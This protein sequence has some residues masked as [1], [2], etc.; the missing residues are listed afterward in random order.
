ML[1]SEAA[2][3]CNSR[4][5]KASQL[6]SETTSYLATFT[7]SPA[8]ELNMSTTADLIGPLGHV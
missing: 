5:V 7:T 6:A 4:Q 3:V 1:V 8:V 2:V